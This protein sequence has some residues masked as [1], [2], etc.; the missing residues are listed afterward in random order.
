M[1][2]MTKQNADNANQAS[3]IAVE[4]RSS[5]ENGS[6]IMS[7]L[8]TSM[9]EINKSSEEISKINKVIEEIAFQ[10]NLLALNAAV[11]AARAGKHG[12]G[13][14]LVAEEVRN[15]A[16]RSAAAAKDTTSLIGEA[17][18]KAKDG[19]EMADRASKSLEE[20]VDSV[21]KVTDLVAEIAAA[22]SEQAQGIDQVNDAVSQMDNVTQHNAASAEQSASASQELT[23]QAD[24]LKEIVNN[25]TN[26][27]SGSSTGN[28]HSHAH[29]GGSMGMPRQ[30][31]ALLRSSEQS[32][33]SYRWSPAMSIGI[34]E[35]DE[36]HK[37]FFDF[38]SQLSAAMK[39][40]RGES[41]VEEIVVGLIEYAANISTMKKRL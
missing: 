16:Q 3:S 34:P 17:V 6:G 8:N 41:T 4:T 39:E 30:G 27:V 29:N 28:G 25:L 7:D 31:T 13:F 5:A 19:S 14:A 21:K 38:L 35:M 9:S 33:V 36:Q 26:V 12:K 22:S 20:I 37:V 1:A 40:Q 11:E 23:G 24:R 2:A 10:T 18:K 32:V 15:L